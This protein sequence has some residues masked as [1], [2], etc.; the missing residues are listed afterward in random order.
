MSFIEFELAIYATTQ[1]IFINP[2]AIS[3]ISEK[4]DKETLISFCY[5]STAS[6]DNYITVKGS[7]EYVK[8]KLIGNVNNDN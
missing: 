4:S 6:E 8:N 3:Y 1:R 7:Y 2:C 5:E